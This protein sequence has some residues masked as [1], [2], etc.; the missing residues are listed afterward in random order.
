MV[1]T[2]LSLVNQGGVILAGHA[3]PTTWVKVVANYL[4]PFCVSNLGFISSQ[5][6]V[7]RSS[8]RR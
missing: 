7:W 5:R 8:L 1:G 6:A 4:I 3:T 2:I